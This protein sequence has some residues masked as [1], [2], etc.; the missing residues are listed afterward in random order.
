LS[1]LR[2]IKPLHR[3]RLASPQ[4]AFNRL[5]HTLLLGQNDD[6]RL[7]AADTGLE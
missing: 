3:D 2:E 6:G 5:V 7:N 1:L 4:E